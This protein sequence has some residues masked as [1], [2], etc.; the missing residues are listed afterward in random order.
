M[1]LTLMLLGAAYNISRKSGSGKPEGQ[2][3]ERLGPKASPEFQA[4]YILDHPL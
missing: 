3:L 2:A 1:K 4:T